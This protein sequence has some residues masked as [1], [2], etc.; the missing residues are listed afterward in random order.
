MTVPLTLDA[1]H[2][3]GSITTG[4]SGVACSNNVC[5]FTDTFGAASPYKT[6]WWNNSYT[7]WN[8]S[9][10]YW[11]GSFVLTGGS[12]NGGWEYASRLYTDML[13][14]NSTPL[15]SSISGS[16]KSPSVYAQ[17]CHGAPAIGSPL[18]M[19][20]LASDP[21]G[22]NNQNNG[23]M[24]LQNGVAG[25]VFNNAPP[26]GRI[27]FE[28]SGPY[29]QQDF[30]TLYDAA[31]VNVNQQNIAANGA[32]LFTQPGTRPAASPGD[33]A[34]S[35][36]GPAYSGS[37]GLALRC[38]NSISNYINS[39]PD[40]NSW[41]EQ[42]TA[43]GKTFNTPVTAN[44]AITARQ[45][46]TAFSQIVSAVPSGTA[47]FAVQSST[48]VGTLTVANHPELQ[49]CV[50]GQGMVNCQGTQTKSGQ[51]VFGTIQLSSG[52][53][54]L[55]NLAPAF[56]VS[57]NCVANDITNVGSGVKAVPNLSQGT[58]VFAGTGSDLISYECVG[59]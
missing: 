36:D 37:N 4:S 44:M 8:D 3:G 33:C 39:L 12:E 57:A 6:Q 56:A 15:I 27:I 14:Y 47:P 53:A 11:P 52:A 5:S 19:S 55:Q 50:S 51:I 25:E 22:G 40:G 2:P 38:Q 16:S 18:W 30:I 46:I 7:L 54:T 34:I 13:A 24:V 17:D 29:A 26:M 48:P 20:C 59:S 41:L 58:I 10:A 35:S 49:N 9:L 31:T 21:V 1:Q 45:P 28:G 43:S 23:P 32:N 42:L